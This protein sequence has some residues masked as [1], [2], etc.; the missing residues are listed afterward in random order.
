M[1]R[2]FA[3]RIIELCGLAGIVI[4]E[5]D[6]IPDTALGILNFCGGTCGGWGAACCGDFVRCIIWYCRAIG[7]CLAGTC[8]HRNDCDNANAN[9]MGG[10]TEFHYY[11]IT[12]GFS[13]RQFL[14]SAWAP[15]REKGWFRNKLQEK[16]SAIKNVADQTKWLPIKLM[17]A[18]RSL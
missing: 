3:I 16:E 12:R 13:C 15:G 18:A 2:D 1:P 8:S 6:D 7:A 14:C 17:K 5:I 4:F 10:G 9:K 11:S